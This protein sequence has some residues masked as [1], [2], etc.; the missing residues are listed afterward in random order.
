MAR[1]VRGEAAFAVEPGFVSYSP[2]GPKITP[3]P[4]PVR[5]LRFDCFT[6]RAACTSAGV[7]GFAKSASI[8]FGSL[9]AANS[10]NTFE[11]LLGFLAAE[12]VM[13]LAR[14]S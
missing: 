8:T 4:K 13:N 10:R 11:L 9:E 2:P 3:Y 7:E 14:S 1:R 5:G 12:Y 6:T